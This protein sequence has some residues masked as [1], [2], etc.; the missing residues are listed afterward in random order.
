MEQQNRVQWVYASTNNQELE[1]RYDQWARDYD[2]DLDQDFGWIC[3]LRGAE[4]IAH[5][6][7]L[8]A[9]ILDAG[10]GTG[11]VG[12]ILANMG[13]KDIVAMDLSQGMLDVAGAKGVY[14]AL[15]Q[16]T[17]GEP[18]GYQDGEFGAVISVG[19]MTLGHAPASSLEELARVTRPGG[20]VVFSLRADMYSPGSEFEHQQS[21]M[22]TQGI[23]TLA[24]VTDPFLGLPKGEPDVYHQVWVYRING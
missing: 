1:E 22:E 24:E 2:S 19:V 5:H 17:L 21:Q 13:Y 6:T 7:P 4:G 3:P 12:E 23:W 18:L 8:D 14:R 9:S 11:L 20:V 15:D 10:A 16:M